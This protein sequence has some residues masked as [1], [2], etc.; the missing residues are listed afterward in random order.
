V[1]PL[2][3]WLGARGL[4]RDALLKIKSNYDAFLEWAAW[5]ENGDRA[6]GGGPSLDDDADGG[7]GTP[8]PPPS[9]HP[10]SAAP[11][12]AANVAA[13]APIVRTDGAA[14]SSPAN[15]DGVAAVVAD[16]TPSGSGRQ[17]CMAA[18][19]VRSHPRLWQAK[20]G[21]LTPLGSEPSVFSYETSDTQFVKALKAPDV[22]RRDPRDP[23]TWVNSCVRVFWPADDMW[24]S[25][26]VVEWLPAAQQHRLLYHEDDEEETLD[27]AAE[28]AAGRVQWLAAASL[29][30]WPPP[31]IPMARSATGR[32]AT[33]PS[34]LSSAMWGAAQTLAAAATAVANVQPGKRI[35]DG[36]EWVPPTA[37]DNSDA[38]PS[39]AA[40]I[41]WRVSI[42][43]DED[44]CWYKGIVDSFDAADGRHRI[45][46]DD[47]EREAV[48]LSLHAVRW[49]SPNAG[50]I[51]AAARAEHART[52]KERAAQLLQDAQVEAA[53]RAANAPTRVAVVCNGMPGELMVKESVVLTARHGIVSPTEFERLAGKGSAKK[54][55]VCYRSMRTCLPLIRVF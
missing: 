4:D 20:A 50:V 42:Y 46:F 19:V 8:A 33:Q 53:E 2:Q 35:V 9:A 25:A 30:F 39:R 48:D 12:P 43:W 22:V 31:P 34:G 37:A 23:R 18:A 32:P 3:E 15:G 40:A 7:G 11:E 5:S 27:L 51:A 10:S 1:L 26:D 38:I 45:H 52:E 6:D 28:D 55:K 54:W 17:A 29:D 41:S 49:H 13:I 14:S 21:G 36:A 16:T 44:G 24:Y 47:G